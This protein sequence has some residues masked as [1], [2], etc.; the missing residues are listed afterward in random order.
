V[1]ASSGKNSPL[2]VEPLRR[3]GESFYFVDVGVQS[4]HQQGLALTGE[5]YFKRA[6]RIAE[7]TQGMDWREL[8]KTRLALADY[9]VYVEAHNRAQK[10]YRE[11]WELLSVD[12]AHMAYRNELFADP[13]PVRTS[14]LPLYSGSGGPSRND[15][16]GGRVI[17]EYTVSTRGRVR[18]LRTESFPPEFT[19][20]QTMV[21]REIRRRIFRPRIV[22]GETVESQDLVFEHPFSYAQA[23][24]DDLRA[25]QQADSKSSDQDDERD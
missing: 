15:Q 18:N 16:K 5:L 9:Y 23:D 6:A 25:A 24:L 13:V 11:V 21:H 17:V 7:R 10:I 14:P 1:E 12:D 20:I 4:P 2:L 8:A 22:E 19:A 3:L